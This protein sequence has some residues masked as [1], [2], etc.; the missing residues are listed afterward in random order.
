[1]SKNLTSFDTVAMQSEL[2]Q[3]CPTWEEDVH[4]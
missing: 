1:M 3:E 4:A 2:V